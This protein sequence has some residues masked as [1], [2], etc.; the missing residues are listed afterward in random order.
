MFIDDLLCADFLQEPLRFMIRTTERRIF[1]AAGAS[2]KDQEATV[3]I[4]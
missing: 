4:V 2:R 1:L 3:A